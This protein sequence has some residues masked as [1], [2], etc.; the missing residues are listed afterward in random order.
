MMISL[1]STAPSVGLRR[2]A[3]TRATVGE[4]G[5]NAHADRLGVMTARSKCVSSCG[6]PSLAARAAAAR[7]CC[8]RPLLN[9]RARE[10]PL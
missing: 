4:C 9:S 7:R 1:R 6:S 5:H 3:P 10:Q 2:S 8:G